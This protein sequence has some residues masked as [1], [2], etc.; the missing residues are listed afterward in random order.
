ME[1]LVRVKG[2]DIDD[3]WKGVDGQ[4]AVDSAIFSDVHGG[5]LRCRMPIYI[6]V[7]YF[8][9]SNTSIRLAEYILILQWFLI[10]I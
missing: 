1:Y 3:H 9:L 2:F 4:V 5:R 6:V 10:I 8:R 7:L